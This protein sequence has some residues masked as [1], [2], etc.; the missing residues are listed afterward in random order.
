MAHRCPRPACETA[1]A[2][3]AFACRPHWFELPLPIRSRIVRAWD[4]GRGR[5]TGAHRTAMLEAIEHWLPDARQAET[6]AAARE[7]VEP[8]TLELEQP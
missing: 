3:Y 1:I 7:A 6:T 4:G 8:L 5:G 2:D